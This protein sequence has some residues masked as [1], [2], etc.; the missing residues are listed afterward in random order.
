MNITVK[1]I[2]NPFYKDSR[3]FSSF[4]N[5]VFILYISKN[6]K[7]RVHFWNI[8]KGIWGKILKTSPFNLLFL[9]SNFLSINA[10][11][12][13]P[14][15]NDP[16][17]DLLDASSEKKINLM[18][19]E[20]LWKNV[21]DCYEKREHFTL[22]YDM[23]SFPKNSIIF[24]VLPKIEDNIE[25]KLV[26]ISNL[27]KQ[28]IINIFSFKD[29]FEQLILRTLLKKNSLGDEFEFNEIDYLEPMEESIFWINYYHYNLNCYINE[30]FYI[31]HSDNK[32]KSLPVNNNALLFI[33]KYPGHPEEA[34][35][36]THLF[37]YDQEFSIWEG[38]GGYRTKIYRSSYDCLL[39]R[40]IG[41]KNLMLGRE[42]VPLCPACEAYI[43][44]KIVDSIKTETDTPFE[45]ITGLIQQKINKSES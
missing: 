8:C 44:T 6:D 27:S 19:I 22:G 45:F 11:F 39:R 37:F 4:D 18:N 34:D 41:D 12:C 10:I 1:H 5:N 16:V 32:W 29:Y 38:G 9:T 23:S 40:K 21:L 7:N 3:V 31:G 35:N 30:P 15:E 14:E 42:K 25:I 20:K 26:E 17:Y 36:H 24:L 28:L 2:T 43:R 13:I 33:N